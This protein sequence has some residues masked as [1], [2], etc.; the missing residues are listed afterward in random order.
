MIRRLLIGCANVSAK[1]NFYAASILQRSLNDVSL[2]P[3]VGLK[4]YRD[5]KK[6]NNNGPVDS[7]DRK[8]RI[9]KTEV[10]RLQWM[11]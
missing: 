2:L 10:S 1:K 5:T 3:F 9:I 4:R 11:A 7:D 8:L 6:A